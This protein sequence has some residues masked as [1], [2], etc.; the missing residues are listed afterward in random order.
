MPNSFLNIHFISQSI[1]KIHAVSKEEQLGAK[2]GAML[3]VQ[4]TPPSL[5]IS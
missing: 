3:E 1:I 5:H 2:R 4:G